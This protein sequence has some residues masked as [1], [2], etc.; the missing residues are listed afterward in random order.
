MGTI[1][2][3][4][5][6]GNMIVRGYLEIQMKVEQLDKKKSTMSYSAELAASDQNVA[7]AWLEHGRIMQTVC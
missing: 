5:T 1:W 3:I 4:W 2:C 6:R 7:S